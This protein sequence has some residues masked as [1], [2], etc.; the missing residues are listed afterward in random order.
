[1]EGA[2]GDINQVKVIDNFLDEENYSKLVQFIDKHHDGYEEAT[3]RPTRW[4]PGHKS[5]GEAANTSWFWTMPV[6]DVF[7]FSTTLLQVINK[8][9][10]QEHTLE[11][12]YFNGMSFGQNAEFHLD[13]TR[14]EAR[15]LLLYVLPCYKWEW[16]GHTMFLD[17]QH[18]DFSVAPC[19]NRATYFPARILHKAFSFVENSAPLRV[20]LAF[21][22]TKKN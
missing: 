16:G 19:P 4:I 17:E 15:T 10:K 3:Y 7:Y 18:K 8:K 6:T 12:V 22:L 11:R 9:L 5:I 20:S 1:M 14:D 21:K 13:D 2:Y